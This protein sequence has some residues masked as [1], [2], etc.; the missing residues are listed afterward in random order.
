MGRGE[1]EG[2]GEGERESERA[3]RC[4]CGVFVYICF[5]CSDYRTPLTSSV[6]VVWALSSVYVY[7]MYSHPMGYL[8]RWWCK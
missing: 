2:E 7:F 1:G 6:F 8:L 4:I 3:Y 5:S